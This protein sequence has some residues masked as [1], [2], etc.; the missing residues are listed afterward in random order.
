MKEIRI[1]KSRILTTDMDLFIY[2][3]LIVTCQ[4]N[5]DLSPNSICDRNAQY[6][7]IE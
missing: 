7:L 1:Q 5:S 6:F 3:N 2:F 4:F